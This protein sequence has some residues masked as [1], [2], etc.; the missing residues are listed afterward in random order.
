M[1]R[2]PSADSGPIWVGLLDLDQEESLREVS[3]PLRADH[4]QTRILVRLHGAPIGYVQVPAR[5]H[6]TLAGRAAT[7]ARA[8]LADALSWHMQSDSTSE[9]DGCHVGAAWLACPSHFPSAG[10]QGVTVAVCTR[11]RATELTEVCLPAVQKIIYE[12][13]D[14]LVIDNAPSSGTTRKAVTGLCREDRRIRYVCEP[15]PGLSRARNRALASAQFDLI[16]F[17]DDD[18]RPDP[19]WVSALAAGFMLDPETVCVTGAVVPIGL[20][21]GSEQYFEARYSWGEVFEPRR[22]DL[23]RHRHP[24]RLYPF[25]AGLFGTGANFAVRREAALQTGGF[26]PLLG[27]GGVGR[28]GED[29]DMFLR[30][31]LAGKRITYL[32]SALVWHQ[33]RVGLQA[34]SEQVYSYGHGLGAYLAKH[35]S[36]PGL[37]AGLRGHGFGESRSALGRARAASEFSHLGLAARRLALTEMRGLMTGAV[38]YR[39]AALARHGA[40]APGD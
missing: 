24:S 25:R 29:L 2:R 27:A 17:T 37:R 38:K 9:Q 16:A 32:P 39:L 30:L 8:A 21:S 7:Q 1:S 35:M 14:I 28:G 26:D 11:D 4:C 20:E 23:A 19:S 5:P 18:V 3:N 33:H 12:P 15:E 10:E 13:L 40:T 36:N 31:V 22:Y 6:E 34:L